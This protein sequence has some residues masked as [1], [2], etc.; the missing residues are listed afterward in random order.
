MVIICLILGANNGNGS[1]HLRPVV[2]LSSKAQVTTSETASEEVG[3]PH[4]I[5]QY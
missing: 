1:N 2:Y 4:A 5:I 3:T